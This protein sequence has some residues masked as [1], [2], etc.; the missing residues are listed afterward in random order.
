ML[1]LASTCN[2]LRICHESGSAVR[3]LWREYN[4]ASNVRYVQQRR[5]E[6]VLGHGGGREWTVDAYTLVARMADGSSKG[7][8][9][10]A[11][12]IRC[13]GEIIRQD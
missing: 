11:A 5:L 10:M 6:C 12:T 7:V 4:H 2:G 3:T 9:N 13:L 8:E 1:T